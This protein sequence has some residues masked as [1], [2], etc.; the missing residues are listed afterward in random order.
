MVITP[1]SDTKDNEMQGGQSDGQGADSPADSDEIPPGLDAKRPS[2]GQEEV[3]TRNDLPRLAA[4]QRQ[5][6]PSRVLHCGRLH[7]K[8]TKVQSRKDRASRKQ[9]QTA[10]NQLK[11]NSI[12]TTSFKVLCTGQVLAARSIFFLSSSL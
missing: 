12:S 9:S 4:T 2:D 10:Y 3:N 6:K 11:F 7:G 1:A 8:G 5:Y